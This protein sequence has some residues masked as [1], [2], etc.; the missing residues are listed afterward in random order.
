MSSDA[1]TY[2]IPQWTLGD[3]LRRIRRD[4]RLSQ[5]DFAARI[6]VGPKAYAAWEADKN[7]PGD[8]VAVA[9]RVQL[10]FGVPA[11]WTL[12]IDGSEPGPGGDVVRH[13][14]LEPRTR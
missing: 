1:I 11:H 13:Q 12:G 5:H 4:V 2:Q 3:R 6:G 8:V 7:R 14:G 9:Q 10:A